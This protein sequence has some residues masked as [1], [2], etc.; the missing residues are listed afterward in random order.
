[1]VNSGAGKNQCRFARQVLRAV[2]SK[3][4][5]SVSGA[6]FQ[7][8]AGNQNITGSPE[9]G[10]R[11]RLIGDPGAGCSGDI[12]RQFNTAA[13]GT[14]TV[15]IVGLESRPD[16]LRGCWNQQFDLALQREFSLGESRHLSFQLD[17]FNAF[18]QSHITGRNTTMT[19][20]STTDPTILN[21][22]FD[23]AGK[24]LAARSQPRTAGFGMASGYQS[25]RTL[26]RV[27]VS[28]SENAALSASVWAGKIRTG[29]LITAAGTALFEYCGSRVEESSTHE[30]PR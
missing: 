2:A 29:G 8:D 25:A 21:L 20:T 9:Y 23:S 30:E 17:A 6:S 16:Y 7:N 11:V 4:Q 3:W 24:L 19:V 22:P 27:F 26:R 18:N 14:P 1:V 13:F 10:G 5:L 15:G 28:R 12:Y